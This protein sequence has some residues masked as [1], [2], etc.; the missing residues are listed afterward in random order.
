ML[1]S[2]PRGLG[3]CRREHKSC[4]PLTWASP[5]KLWM[6]F[7]ALFT[8]KN[9]SSISPG[10]LHRPKACNMGAWSSPGT[11]STSPCGHIAESVLGRQL[12]GVPRLLEAMEI[13]PRDPSGF[14]TGPKRGR[15]GIS[16][17]HCLVG[18]FEEAAS[19][20]QR[21]LQSWGQ[22]FPAV[23]CGTLGELGWSALTL[24]PPALLVCLAAFNHRRS[25]EAAWAVCRRRLAKE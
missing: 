21:S 12:G 13:I 15:T 14:W 3:R 4:W 24:H 17:P 8:T 18:G 10:S 9:H 6:C 7:W 22:A 19:V 25:F 2:V 20:R 5:A 16:W 1:G 23:N 11:V